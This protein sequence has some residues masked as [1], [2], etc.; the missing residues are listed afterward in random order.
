M[1]LHMRNLADYIAARLSPTTGTAI[2]V[3][4]VLK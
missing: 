4:N 3:A 2:S 1:E